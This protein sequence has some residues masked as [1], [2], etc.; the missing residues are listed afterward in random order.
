MG[1][2]G[3]AVQSRAGNP[4]QGYYTGYGPLAGGTGSGMGQAMAGRGEFAPG[5]GVTV[6]G[7]TWHPT[8][9]YLAAL[10]IAEMF[11]FGLVSQLLK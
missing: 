4:A 8:V 11:V 10:V 9:L 3:E 6:G 7:Q 5:N 2:R 1:W